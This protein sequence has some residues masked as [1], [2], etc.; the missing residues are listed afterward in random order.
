MPRFLLLL[1]LVPL[2][3]IWILVRVGSVL[4]QTY[5]AGSALLIIL[6]TLF[7]G[8]VLGKWVM[9]SKGSRSLQDLQIAIARGAAPADALIDGLLKVLAGLLFIFPGYLTDV[10][11]VFL[12][13]PWVRRILLGRAKTWLARAMRR[14][15]VFTSGQGPWTG[16]QR[17]Y[18]QGRSTLAQDRGDVI[19]VTATDA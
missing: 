14:G 5:D 15:Q 17:A 6:S 1:L 11:A 19:D 12:L 2:A 10:F 8:L 7:L 4:T 9:R 18:D 16:P 13:L 3:E